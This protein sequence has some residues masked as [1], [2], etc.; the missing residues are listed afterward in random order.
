MKP[1]TI[2]IDFDQ[3]WTADPPAWLT[4]YHLMTL[5]GHTVIIITR[6][7]GPS[8]D[9]FRHSLPPNIPVVFCDNEFKQP[10]AIRHGYHVDIWIDDQPGTICP[11][12]I[13]NP[14]PDN[15]L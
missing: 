8:S 14:V 15:S 5:R 11:N 10:I 6:R 2:A 12:T 3:T 4:F 7:A 1:L 9:M 13:L